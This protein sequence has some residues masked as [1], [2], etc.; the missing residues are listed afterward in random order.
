VRR[1]WNP[2]LLQVGHTGPLCPSEPGRPIPYLD[3]VALDFPELVIVAGHI[4]YPWTTEM[5]ALATKYPNLYI[6]TSAYKASRYPAELVDYLKRHGR[7]KVLFG[8]NHPAWPALECLRDL[9]GA[10]PH[11][12][13]QAALRTLL[14]RSCWTGCRTGAP[15]GWSPSPRPRSATA[16]TCCLALGRARVLPARRQLHHQPHSPVGDRRTK[17]RLTQEQRAYNRLQAGLRVLVEQSI[18]HLTG[19]WA[20]RRWRGLQSRVR[21]VYRAAGALVCLGRWLHRIPI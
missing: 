21:D 1:A 5:I 2:F 18:A 11:R 16:S 3:H 13:A 9:P 14:G 20:L 6:D 17:D 8:S 7:A 15:P 4:G 12:P 10:L 19:A